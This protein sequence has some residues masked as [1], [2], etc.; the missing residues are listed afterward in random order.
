MYGSFDV[1]ATRQHDV[2]RTVPN[3]KS[4]PHWDRPVCPMM[5]LKVLDRPLDLYLQWCGKGRDER[6]AREK[7]NG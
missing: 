3:R 7:R 4:N 5:H 2:A 6:P 1:R